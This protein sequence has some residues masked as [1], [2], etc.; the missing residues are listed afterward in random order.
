LLLQLDP[1]ELC[2]NCSFF[3]FLVDSSCLRCLLLELLFLKLKGCGFFLKFKPL[4]F[5][6]EFRLLLLDAES[7]F[8]GGEKCSFI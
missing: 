6:E 7:F 4:L 8:F 2:S 1:L 3:K 5:G